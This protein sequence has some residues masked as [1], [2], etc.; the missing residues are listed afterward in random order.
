MLAHVGEHYLAML[1]YVLAQHRGYARY[2]VAQSRDRRLYGNN[3]FIMRWA[4]FDELCRFWFD[5]LF[6]IEAM[7]DALPA[8][9]QQRVLAFLSERIFDL[10]VRRLNEAGRRI[11]E[12]P[13][14]CLR[15]S[16]LAPDA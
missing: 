15:D 3:M 5:C 6:G 8:G 7:L 2:V 10:H 14:F 16:A 1:N 4:D 9:Y 11:V 12:R 13:V